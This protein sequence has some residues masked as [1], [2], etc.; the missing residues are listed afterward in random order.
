MTARTDQTAAEMWAVV[1]LSSSQI[2]AQGGDKIPVVELLEPKLGS[3]SPSATPV[4]DV[5]PSAGTLSAVIAN[6]PFPVMAGSLVVPSTWGAKIRLGPV[7][8]EP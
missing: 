8:R 5:A 4:Q 7:V 6:R 1:K 2:P 3:L